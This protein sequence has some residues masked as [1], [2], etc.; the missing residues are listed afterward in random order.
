M[1]EKDT[2]EILEEQRRARQEFLELKKMQSGEMAAPPARLLL[3][4]KRPRKNGITSGFSINGM[5]WR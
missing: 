4:P 1:S 5:L 2:N 3:F